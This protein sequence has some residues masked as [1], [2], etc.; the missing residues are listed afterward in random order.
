M[1]ILKQYKKVIAWALVILIL[2]SIPGSGFDKLQL[3]FWKI[4]HLDKLIHGG[5]YFTL[6]LLLI[7]V[8]TKRDFKFPFFYAI[9]LAIFYGGIMELLQGYVFPGRAAE[10]LDFLANSI[11][12]SVSFWGYSYLKRIKWLGFLFN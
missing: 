4:I 3:P 7:S 11:G 6:S 1:I 2:S 12:A 5:M 9:N 10:W 8:F